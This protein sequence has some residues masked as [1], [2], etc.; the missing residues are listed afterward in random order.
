MSGSLD[1][2]SLCLSTINGSNHDELS[3]IVEAYHSETHWFSTR[4][5]VILILAYTLVVVLG[6]VGNTLVCVVVFVRKDLRNSRNLYILNLSVCDL[7]MCSVCLPFSLVKYTVKRWTL[8]AIMC[9][10][11]PALATVDV[12]VSTFT[13]IAIAVD[14]YK[15]IVHASR[16]HSQ[17]MQ[18][19]R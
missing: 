14:R 12:F 7:I 18:V 16:D 3:Q 5:L 1:N 19:G 8:G 6:V 10:I 2:C 17:S 4:T 13:I 15:A 9:S 11:V